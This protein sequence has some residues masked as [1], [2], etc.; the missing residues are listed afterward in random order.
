MG[1]K[2]STLVAYTYEFKRISGILSSHETQMPE[3]V[4][5]TMLLSGLTPAYQQVK[6][7]Y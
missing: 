6:L 2:L 3:V 1:R 5:V 7:T 4:L